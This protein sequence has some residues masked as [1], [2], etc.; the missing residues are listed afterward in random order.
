MAKKNSVARK[1]MRE[2][3]RLRQLA[4]GL[5]RAKDGM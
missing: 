1:E 2:G 5:M 3:K 4:P